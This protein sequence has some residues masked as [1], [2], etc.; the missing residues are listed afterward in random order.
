G[1]AQA[2]SPISAPASRTTYHDDAMGFDFAYPS[3]FH[4]PKTTTS[5][6]PSKEQD[7][8]SGDKKAE[9]ECVTSPIGVMDMRTDFNMIFLKRYDMACLGVEI[10]AAGLGAASARVLTHTL[11]NYGKPLVGSATDYEVAGHTAS[12]VSGSVKV[13]QAKGK[14]VLFG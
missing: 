3:T 13:P 6:V 1:Y 12:T 2:T 14:S 10:T 7:K 9:P 4:P 5:E 11:E 8:V